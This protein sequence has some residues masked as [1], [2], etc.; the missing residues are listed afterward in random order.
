MK[1]RREVV[2]QTAK[3]ERFS[4]IYYD[5]GVSLVDSVVMS[6]VLLWQELAM[7]GKSD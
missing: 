5:P 1:H 4:L 3:R 7:R 6:G 2:G